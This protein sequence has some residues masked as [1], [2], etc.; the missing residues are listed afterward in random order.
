MSGLENI[1]IL[2]AYALLG[3]IEIFFGFQLFRAVATITGALLGMTFGPDVYQQFIGGTPEIVASAISAAVGAILFGVL[4]YM[5]VWLAALLWGASL[6][7]ALGVT[8]AAT[9]TWPVVLAVLL[10]GFAAA[11]TRPTIA[12]LT[13]MHGAWLL[14]ATIAALA[15]IV[16]FYGIYPLTDEQLMFTSFPWLASVALGV[17]LLG[18]IFQLRRAALSDRRIGARTRISTR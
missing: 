11:F 5:G 7:F 13:G 4:S 15:E 10:G 18:T 17:G 9:P 1:L 6:G 12:V 8:F 3:I 16:P 14:S 2:T